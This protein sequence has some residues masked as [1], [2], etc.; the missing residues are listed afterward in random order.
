[1][2]VISDIDSSKRDEPSD[3]SAS[4]SDRFN[5]SRFLSR[6][7]AVRWWVI[8]AMMFGYAS[9]MPLGPT[10][11]ESFA[12]YGY[13]PSWH[14]IQVLFFLSGVMA[15][16][17][18]SSGRKGL[19]YL[20]S[21]FWRN[22]PMLGFLTIATLI[23]LFPLFGTPMDSG[24]DF[25]LRVTK[26]VLLTT[27]CIDP[28]IPI[29][30]LMD[31]SHYMCLI[32]GG[33][34]TLRFGLILHILAALSG[35]LK[36]L[37]NRHLLLLGT[38]ASTVTYVVASYITAKQDIS[39][40][41]SLLAA[42]RLSYAFLVG[43]SF[44]AYRDLIAGFG[45]N[46]WLAPIFLFI[47]ASINYW[48]LTWTP[49]IEVSLTLAWMSVGW[50]LLVTSNKLCASLNN[51]PNMALIL[52]VIGWPILQTL[53][54]IFPDLGRW[55]L[56]ALSLPFMAILTWVLHWALINRTQDMRVRIKRAAM[57]AT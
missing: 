24:G 31:D 54:I 10:F 8:M 34:W 18:L 28:G 50:G 49:I 17:S 51:W 46:I 20:R 36:L 12:L 1:M 52:M 37:P 16:R 38:V 53:L 5:E 26:Y 13:D 40:F 4:I 43:M 2:S 6:L 41:D 29:Q 57:P 9:T 15:Y 44:W 25:F 3:N 47:I 55:S 11:Q 27:F 56:P 32:Q 23:V 7:N 48:G 30:G 14:A 45:R 19:E 39:A 33:L 42:L 35:T 22:V 21:R